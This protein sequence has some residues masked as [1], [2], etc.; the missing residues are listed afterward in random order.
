M[1]EDSP[2]APRA[3]APPRPQA[4][5][6]CGPPATLRC[7][8]E[9]ARRRGRA[10]P[11]RR[12]PGIDRDAGTRLEIASPAERTEWR[13]RDRD[14]QRHDDD[15]ASEE[16]RAD[17][18]EPPQ[19]TG[20]HAQRQQRGVV[21]CLPLEHPRH[22]LSGQQPQ[23]RDADDRCGPERLR[24]E[25]QPRLHRAGPEIERR[26]LEVVAVGEPLRSAFERG[27]SAVPCHR[28]TL[29]ELSRRDR[30]PGAAVRAVERGGRRADEASGLRRDHV[31]PD[32]DDAQGD[33]RAGHRAT[34]EMETDGQGV[35]QGEMSGPHRARVR[36]DLVGAAG[37]G[38]PSRQQFRPIHDLEPV[39][40]R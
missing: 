2:G 30:D 28:R 31:G 29:S 10:R 4:R 26:E 6:G 32:A 7:H 12:A 35:A 25:V 40:I 5:N 16:E 24:L 11:R 15:H 39:G 3:E 34:T 19:V 23:R 22:A 20:R 14:R 36:D 33:G 1:S 9:A 27:T 17:Q 8:R 18:S 38:Q 13:E 37:R 21:A